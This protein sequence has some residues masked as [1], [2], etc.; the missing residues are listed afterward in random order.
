ME[1]NGRVWGSLPLA[2]HSGVDFPAR[3][4]AL[5]LSE[6]PPED[7]TVDMQY[8]VGVRS[9][10]LELDMLWIASVLS[11]KQ[12]YPFIPMPGRGQGVLALLGLFNPANRFDILSLR[13]PKPGLAEL[14]KIITKLGSKLRESA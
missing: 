5:Y 3:L 9:R 7:A 14:P 2:V 10:N 11:G 12:R 13:D 1:I 8:R 4:A 6:P